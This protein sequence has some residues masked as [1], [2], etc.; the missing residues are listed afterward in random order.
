MFGSDLTP[1]SYIAKGISVL[2]ANVPPNHRVTDVRYEPSVAGEPSSIFRFVADVI[3]E[4]RIGKEYERT[5]GAG[6][7]TVSEKQ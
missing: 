1:I 2:M 7:V 5:T 3:R 6:G 4:D